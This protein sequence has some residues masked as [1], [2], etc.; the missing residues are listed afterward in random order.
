MRCTRCLSTFNKSVYQVQEYLQ[1]ELSAKMHRN[2]KREK[3]ETDGQRQRQ[4]DWLS[5]KGQIRTMPYF[6]KVIDRSVKFKL[7]R[8]WTDDISGTNFRPGQTNIKGSDGLPL[9]RAVLE[10]R[11]KSWT[12]TNYGLVRIGP[13]KQGHCRERAREC[14]RAYVRACVK[15]IQL[16]S[17][18]KVNYRPWVGLNHQPFG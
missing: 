14:M 11:A 5:D 7:S 13:S 9:R 1:R 6:A 18:K 4:T 8:V 12:K 15:W 2:R 10:Q 17:L 3:R 16:R